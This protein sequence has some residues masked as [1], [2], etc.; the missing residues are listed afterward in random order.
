MPVI[1]YYIKNVYGV[2]RI[3]IKDKDQA[4][5]FYALTGSKTVSAAQL[6][7]LKILGFEVQHEPLY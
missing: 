3:Y 7:A 4:D 2:D 1:K 6:A 5:A